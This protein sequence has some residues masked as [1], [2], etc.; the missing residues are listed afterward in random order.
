[1][2]SRWITRGI[3]FAVA[4]AFFLWVQAQDLQK[5]E[6]TFGDAEKCRSLRGW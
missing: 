3:A 4:L 6:R 2:T 1:M 5:C